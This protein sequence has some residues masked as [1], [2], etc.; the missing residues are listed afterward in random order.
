M[1]YITR[2]E[3]FNA[4]HRLYREEWSEEKNFAVF[5][6]CA[7]PNFHGHNFTL[8]VTVRGTP[9][10]ETGFVTDL[11]KLSELIKDVI[12]EK[13]DHRNLNM[14]VDFMKGTVPSIENLAKGIWQELLPHIK[15][16]ELHAVKLHETENQYVEY[17]G[18]K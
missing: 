11:K 15:D 10:D 17:F 7:N 13:L 4:A 3:H 8:Y 14:D 1:I 2:K 6:R 12:V 16:C 5:G 18:S 9:S